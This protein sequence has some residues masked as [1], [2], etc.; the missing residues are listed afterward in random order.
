MPRRAAAPPHDVLAAMAHAYVAF[1]AGF[2]WGVPLAESGAR[3]G[4]NKF[5]K[6]RVSRSFS[7]NEISQSSSDHSR[8]LVATTDKTCQEARFRACSPDDPDSGGVREVGQGRPTV[9]GARVFVVT[10]VLGD[11]YCP[12]GGGRTS[13]QGHDA[14][15]LGSAGPVR[16]LP[17]RGA[18]PHS[19]SGSGSRASGISGL[20][21]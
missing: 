17:A 1:L 9:E 3:E 21:S 8:S 20:A 18:R 12:E 16:A 6:K 5:I 15:G 14:G 4:L 19:Q 2:P 11:G 13:E 10:S 7:R